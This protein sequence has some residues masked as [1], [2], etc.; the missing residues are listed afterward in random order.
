MY[1]LNLAHISIII[2]GFIFSTFIQSPNLWWISWNGKKHWQR[3]GLLTA[4]W[5][6]LHQWNAV[7]LLVNF[8]KSVATLSM[9]AKKWQCMTS[10]QQAKNENF[11]VNTWALANWPNNDNFWQSFDFSP[12]NQKITIFSSIMTNFSQSCQN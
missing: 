1:F 12:K 6:I 7:M 11:L 4:K 5:K 9:M 3:R 8:S 2:F 10:C